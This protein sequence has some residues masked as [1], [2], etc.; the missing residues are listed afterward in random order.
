MKV[1]CTVKEPTLAVNSNIDLIVESTICTRGTVMLRLR[2][3][4]IEVSAEE[5]KKAIDNCCN[6]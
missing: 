5:L 1:I 2:D 4:A 3:V 6:I